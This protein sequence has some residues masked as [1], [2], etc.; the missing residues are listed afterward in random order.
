MTYNFRY[1]SSEHFV[2]WFRN[3]YGPTV[4]A[5]AALEPEGQ[6]AL[7]RDLRELLEERN[8]SGDETLVVPSE[9]LEAVAVRR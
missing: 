2:D 4:R 7:E 1:P 9:Y 8:T 6:N 5:F 3:Y